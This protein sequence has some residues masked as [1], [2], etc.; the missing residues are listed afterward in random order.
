MVSGAGDR[1]RGEKE[2]GEIKSQ[3]KREKSSAF[4]VQQADVLSDQKN[5]LSGWRG[6][7]ATKRF[8][9]RFETITEPPTDRKKQRGKEKNLGKTGDKEKVHWLVGEGP[10]NLKRTCP[11]RKLNS[12][13]F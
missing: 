8:D 4:C 12:S 10:S 2:R 5:S 11:S 3:K 13:L 9:G 7:R 6:Y 1:K